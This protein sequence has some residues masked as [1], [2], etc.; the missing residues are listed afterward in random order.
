[1]SR[2]Y[3]L[4][5]GSSV[6]VELRDYIYSSHTTQGQLNRYIETLHLSTLLRDG[7]SRGLFLPQGTFKGR[8]IKVSF[9]K[10]S[11]HWQVPPDDE[12]SDD[13]SLPKRIALKTLL[14]IPNFIKGFASET[15]L[16]FW[17]ITHKATHY[18]FWYTVILYDTAGEANEVRDLQRELHAI[19]KVAVVINAGEI[20]GLLQSEAADGTAVNDQSL[21]SARERIKTG[22]DRKQKLYIVVTQM[23]RIREQIKDDWQQVETIADSIGSRKY[24]REAKDLLRKWLAQSQST[25]AA[26][27]GNKLRNVTSVFFVWTEDLPPSQ[28]PANQAKLPRSRGIAKFMCD[29]LGVKT[30]QIVR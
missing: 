12:V 30:D 21:R 24:N 18:P 23:D 8:N 9:I 13:F 16:V 7:Q 4:H 2:G 14:A 15:A 19:D 26:E 6:E 22:I 1:N 5:N 29:C 27:L 10:P 3:A 17:Q 11:K 25:H 20:F 28:A